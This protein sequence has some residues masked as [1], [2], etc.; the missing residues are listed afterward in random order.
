MATTD[1]GDNWEVDVPADTTLKPGDDVKARDE[2]GNES[3]EKVGN[4]M[5]GIDTGKCIATSVG[6]GLPLITLLPI[7]LATQFEIP[8]LSDIAAQANAQIQ[9]V[10]TQVQRQLGLFNPQLASQVVAMNAQS[11]QYGTDIGIVLGGLA[12]I[13]AGILAGTIIYDNCSPNGGGSSVKDLELKGSSGR[14]YAGS[15][16]ERQAPEKK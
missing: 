7:G 1:N 8:G 4:G 11:G 6:F 14:T 13:S 3:T 15:S 5:P 12:L 9:N 10:N 2:A 16:K